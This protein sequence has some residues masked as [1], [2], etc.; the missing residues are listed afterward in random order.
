VGRSKKTPSAILFFIS[1]ILDGFS[2]SFFLFF[3]KNTRWVCWISES[4]ER[5][6]DVVLNWNSVQTVT[7]FKILNDVAVCIRLDL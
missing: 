4:D 2:F 7:L 1:R 3:F 6:V 5:H